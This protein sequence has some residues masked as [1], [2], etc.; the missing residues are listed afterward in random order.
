[1][2]TSSLQ[3]PQKCWKNLSKTARGWIG[4]KCEA[5]VN[6]KRWRGQTPNIMQAEAEGTETKMMDCMRGNRKMLKNEMFILRVG[7]WAFTGEHLFVNSGKVNGRWWKDEEEWR[8]KMAAGWREGGAYLPVLFVS[9]RL[10]AWICL[11]AGQ[12]GAGFV[13]CVSATTAHTA[14][15]EHRETVSQSTHTHVY[16][17]V[18]NYSLKGTNIKKN[19]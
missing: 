4:S 14:G 1:M 13:V 18:N 10:L 19:Q 15:G 2:K 6:T 16:T 9:Q 8:R 3:S 11:G 17:Q 5:A 7:K 12:E